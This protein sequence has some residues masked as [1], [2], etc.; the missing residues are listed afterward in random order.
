ME[1]FKKGDIVAWT[2]QSHGSWKPKQGVIVAVIPKNKHAQPYL[3]AGTKL[4]DG[5]MWV[6]RNHRSYLVRVGRRSMLYWPLVK[7]LR[8]A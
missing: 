1:D 5:Q 3:P 2:S 6:T 8:R 4:N 7:D